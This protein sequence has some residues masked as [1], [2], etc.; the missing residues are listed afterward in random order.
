[1]TR[2]D[3][4]YDP[5]GDR[6]EAQERADRALEKADPKAITRVEHLPHVFG[7][8]TNPYRLAAKGRGE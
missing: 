7:L 3:P 4:I 2:L 6:V 8:R 1:M 5:D